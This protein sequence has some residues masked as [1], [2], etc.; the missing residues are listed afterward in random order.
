M[1]DI[2]RNLERA[3]RE[4]ISILREALA[5]LQKSGE[6]VG[7]TPKPVKKR[8]G[9]GSFST[10]GF[11]TATAIRTRRSFGMSEP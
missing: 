7:D 4:L 10:A 6:Q 8:L 3:V 5:S 1:S 2:G 11:S 9:A